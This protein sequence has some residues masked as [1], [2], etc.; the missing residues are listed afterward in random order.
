MNHTLIFIALL[1][2]GVTPTYL[3]GLYIMFKK[4]IIFSIGSYLTV[5]LV[6]VSICSHVVGTYGLD[7]MI[8]AAPVALASL[9][10]SLWLIFSITKKRFNIFTSQVQKL[11]RGNLN[12]LFD[13]D[14]LS[15]KDELGENAKDLNRLMKELQKVV[16][17]IKNTSN[18][19][20][21]ASNILV[22]NSKMIANGVNEQASSTEEISSSMEQIVA[23][24]RSNSENAQLTNNIS[25]KAA[26]DTRD[27]QKSI[28]NTTSS[29][30]DINS[31]ISIITE[32]AR[33][34]NILALN[35]AVEAAR[36]GDH[37][38]GFA[39]V[40]QEVRNLAEK[41][42]EA[43]IEITSLAKNN[44][45]IAVKSDDI[46]ENIV[47]DI[48]RTADLIQEISSA[49]IEQNS[50][51]EQINSSLQLLNNITQQNV[52]AVEE[53]NKSAEELRGQAEYLNESITF[54]KLQ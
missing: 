10:I 25:V 31:K 26:T 49:S 23:S 35:A 38:R 44:F 46:F 3:L 4:S 18:H 52:D 8:W 47:P 32:I 28:K 9:F 29:I 1:F 33:Q 17:G 21:E 15:K 6:T 37:G 45:N 7:E 42:Q 40:A 19:L 50:S 48:E 34:T 12:S 20:M 16:K 5:A 13:N 11:S 54:F 39:V 53:M 22:H 14:Y 43:A 24:I 51:S 27:C 41:S 36:A 30:K 2:F